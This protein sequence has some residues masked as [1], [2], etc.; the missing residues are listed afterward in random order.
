MGI[1]QKIHDTFFRDPFLKKLYC[2]ASYVK[3]KTL[4]SLKLVLPILRYRMRHDTPVFLVFTPEHANLGDHAIAYAE[5]QMFD[6]LNI[7]FYEVTGAQLYTLRHYKF[8]KVLN[9]ASVFVSG[10]GN[11]G[12]LW[13]EIESMNRSL[14][15]ELADATICILPNS[16]YY[17]DSPDGQ[18]E[19]QKSI[20]IYNRHP[21]LYLYAREKLSF[22][23]MQSIYRHVKLSPDMVL[24]LTPALEQGERA[25]CLICM[26]DDV[27][28]TV[29]ED[30]F[31][32]I[33][34][35]AAAYFEKVSFTN[36]V[37]DHNVSV[38]DRE[39]ELNKK[40]QE[41]SRAEL[42]IT[43]R[44][45]GMIFCAITGTKCIVL[46]GKSPKI[47]GCYEWLRD[48][49]YITFVDDVAGLKAAYQSLTDASDHYCAERSGAMFER[50]ELD[51]EHLIRHG[52]WEDESKRNNA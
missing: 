1:K 46:S 38:Q 37:L 35:M 15:E 41:F 49:G 5:K 26:R 12:T 43:D 16:I 47:Q 32:S 33:C 6:R 34:E 28:R 44:L 36:T 50:L 2:G 22:S 27:E 20:E 7:S 4:C 11:L 25:G 13:P 39:A 17:E 31:K 29:S 19:L 45:H 24:S 9:H 18:R 14:I 48:L 52:D 51:V 10:G 8:L 23:L 42:V 21:R 40:F 30:D 3:G